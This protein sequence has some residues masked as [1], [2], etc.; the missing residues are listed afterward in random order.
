MLVSCLLP[1]YNRYPDY[2][3]LVEEAVYSFLQQDYQN[4]E[5]IICNDTPGQS[6]VIQHPRIKCVN[7]AQRFDTLGNK[8]HYML[9]TLAQGD[10]VCRWDDDD[11]SLP[12]RLSYSVGRLI[13]L[14]KDNPR[15][16]HSFRV[17]SGIVS[18][19]SEWRPENHWFW[20]GGKIVKETQHPGN[21][22]IMAIW[23]RGILGTTHERVPNSNYED[24][25]AYSVQDVPVTYPGTPCPSGLED[26]TFT[27]QLRSRGYP[28]FGDL[29][30]P[31][32]IFYLY[33]WGVQAN[34]LSGKGGMETMQRTYEQIGQQMVSKQTYT[35][36]P[37]WYQDYIGLAAIAARQPAK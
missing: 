12:W 20:N 15:H 31:Q 13:Q 8:I 11:I 4:K 17:P 18:F 7:L 3:N 33:R 10:F 37:K 32:D 29:L 34:H 2:P 21:T 23:H 26:Q 36:R 5:L 24:I 35:I 14:A 22:H 28:Q 9:H 27:A 6:I 30:P 19:A 1:T 25:G 16:C